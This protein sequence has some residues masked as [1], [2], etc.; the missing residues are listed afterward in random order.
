MQEKQWTPT[1]EEGRV[2]ELKLFIQ[3]LD[4]I[5][6][7]FLSDHMMNLLEDVEGTLPLEKEKMIGII[8]SFLTMDE[9]DKE[10]F[11]IGR[12]LGHFRY[13]SDYYNNPEIEKLREKLKSRFESVDK[14]VM[15][16]LKN[17]IW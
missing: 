14:A 13:L 9:E 12:R 6:S 4:G 17:Y 5:T 15:E 8:D 7:T 3:N 10:N 16:I 11:I 1:T 2:R